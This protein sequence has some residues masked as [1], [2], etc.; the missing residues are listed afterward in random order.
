M[1]FNFPCVQASSEEAKIFC[2]ELKIFKKGK[3]RNSKAKIT[4]FQSNQFQYIPSPQSLRRKPPFATREPPAMAN[5]GEPIGKIQLISKLD[6]GA[7]AQ[8]TKTL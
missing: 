2:F 1:A 8:Q 6:P 4:K 3:L 7:Q 5:N